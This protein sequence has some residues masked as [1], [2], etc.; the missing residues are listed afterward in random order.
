MMRWYQGLPLETRRL[1]LIEKYLPVPAAASDRKK[2]GLPIRS[3]WSIGATSSEIKSEDA[4]KTGKV[5]ATTVLIEAGSRLES[6][7][8]PAHEF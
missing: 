5:N 7:A 2:F 3:A 6:A 8:Q 4:V 1:P